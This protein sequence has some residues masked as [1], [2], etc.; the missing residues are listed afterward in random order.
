[1][2]EQRDRAAS[3]AVDRLIESRRRGEAEASS[4]E[5]LGDEKE[6]ATLAATLENEWRQQPAAGEDAIWQR[7][8]VG[9]HATPQSRPR[10]WS[11]FPSALAS[12]SL[13]A[14]LPPSL[15]GRTPTLVTTALALVL[16][17]LATFAT[18]RQ[19][20][21]ATFVA[22]VEN[23]ASFT[24]AV[25]NDWQLSPRE[26]GEVERRAS[27][28]LSV[29]QANP[30]VVA[31]LDGSDAELVVSRIDGILTLLQPYEDDQHGGVETSVVPLASVRE[32][33]ESARGVPPTPGAFA[34]DTATPTSTSAAA[35]APTAEQRDEQGPRRNP[36]VA[37]TPR[38][39]ATADA[40][41]PSTATPP[42]ESDGLRP[43]CGNEREAR[44]AR[45]RAAMAELEG[46][47]ERDPRSERCAG[48]VED[49]LEACR[50]LRDDDAAAGCE[51]ALLA[52]TGAFAPDGDERDDGD[53]N[54]RNGDDRDRN[55]DD[56]GPGD[57]DGDRRAG[58]DGDC[59]G[60]D[61]D[62]DEADRNSGNEGSGDDG[63]SGDSGGND[64]DDDDDR[65]DPGRWFGRGRGGDD[66]R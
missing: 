17:V 62:R 16:V 57:G 61:D 59:E 54:D 1:M 47:C 39:T 5:L 18:Q 37:P 31:Q 21:N 9:V 34:A 38:V 63:D 32:Q 44:Q 20:A 35:A 28:L 56:G 3:E 64:N 24:A 25:L 49:A 45:C 23:L 2:T 43:L 30:S 8:S 52:L 7:V 27:G 53:D 65:S 42:L 46:A 51:R 48:A 10:R 12:F 6:L 58:D 55:E 19:S 26:R 36:D 4:P 15:I 22:D 14:A 11:R 41:V 60:D 66:S 13:P 33:V 29:V 50:E 40:R